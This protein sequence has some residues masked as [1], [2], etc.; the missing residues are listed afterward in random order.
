MAN[1]TGATLHVGGSMPLVCT[2]GVATP[3]G[4]ALMAEAGFATP[5]NLIH[6]RDGEDHRRVLREL[7]EQGNKLVVQYLHPPDETP[8]GDYWVRPELLSHI[9]NK[10]MLGEFVRESEV[11]KRR[12]VPA[13]S[14][15]EMREDALP[16]V[17][18][19]ATDESSGGGLDVLIC[20]EASDL[21]AAPEFF[22][23]ADQVVVEEYLHLVRNLCL[24]F[25]VLE[26]GGVLYLGGAEQASGADGR[27][28]GNWVRRD[29][30]VPQTAVEVAREAVSAAADLG[31]RGC[32]GI[33]VGLLETGEVRVF[34]LNFRLNNSTVILLLNDAIAERHP[35]TAARLNSW[36]CEAGFD[37]ML[38]IAS[39]AMEHGGFLPLGSY[40]PREDG[41]TEAQ[42]RL[43]GL[44]LGDSPE[45]VEARLEIL[46]EKGLTP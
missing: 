14:L 1:A 21:A 8:Y 44:V 9:N 40:D 24:G 42:P 4:L 7:A 20:R 45:E 29:L 27:F 28:E 15:G 10:A 46:Q 5:E 12:V 19:A 6:Y 38:R 17:V 36:S 11:P 39:R 26:D 32:V 23:K 30:C 43:R 31:Y 2:R 13:T 22:A 25:A 3:S 16:L 33:D 41:Y 37:A 18:K 35:F 34:D